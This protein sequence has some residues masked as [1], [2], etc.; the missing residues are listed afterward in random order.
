[1]T[2]F[3]ARV[4]KDE[5]TKHNYVNSQAVQVWTT[6]AA[7]HKRFVNTLNASFE[8]NPNPVTLDQLTKEDKARSDC[9][10]IAIK[11]AKAEKNQGWGY[12]EM[13]QE[14]VNNLV[15]KYEGDLS[16]CTEIERKTI[17]YIE[18]LDARRKQLVEVTKLIPTRKD[19]KQ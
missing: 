17:D 7:R 19:G 3:N 9:V 11:T 14:Y 10:E 4:F 18:S 12:L 6:E 1:M 2:D 16:Q 13:G 8:V 15:M 5:M